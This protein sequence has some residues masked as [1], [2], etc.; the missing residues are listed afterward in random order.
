M[1]PTSSSYG[2][3]VLVQADPSDFRKLYSMPTDHGH[4]SMIKLKDRVSSSQRD[5]VTTNYSL[6]TVL[7]LL[8]YCLSGKIEFLGLL[9]LN[10]VLG[11]IAA[12]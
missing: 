8:L 12:A 10:P 6:A 9:C 11:A 4:A 3:G 5:I 1:Y 7:C 2:A